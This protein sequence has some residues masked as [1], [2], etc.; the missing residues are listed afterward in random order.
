MSC[1]RCSLLELDSTSVVDKS[2]EHNNRF[3]QL[4]EVK[5]FIPLH[6]ISVCMSCASF[7]PVWACVWTGSPSPIPLCP[8]NFKLG[9]KKERGRKE[10]E[11]ERAY[12]R[13]SALH[14]VSCWQST[15]TPLLPTPD[16]SREAGDNSQAT[17]TAAKAVIDR[18]EIWPHWSTY[19][20]LRLSQTQN[21]RRQRLKPFSFGLRKT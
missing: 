5:S 17:P 21:K 18:L 2:A 20:L 11:R 9:G 3:V 8:P 6:T 10:R 1:C 16:Q 7:R 4:L 12:K 14:H 15:D 19:C 13:P